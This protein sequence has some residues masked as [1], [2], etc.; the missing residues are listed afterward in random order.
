M[1]FLMKSGFLNGNNTDYLELGLFL[2]EKPGFS[3]NRIQ[4]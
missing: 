2:E 4:M 1:N 3:R